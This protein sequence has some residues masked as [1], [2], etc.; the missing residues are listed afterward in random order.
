MSFPF[1][2]NSIFNQAAV[3]AGD[4][5]AAVSG[6]S[7]AAAGEWGVALSSG[8]TGGEATT[9][10]NG[11]SYSRD[12][13]AAAG[14]GGFAIA[15]ARNAQVIAGGSGVALGTWLPFVESG[16]GGLSIS[17]NGGVVSTGDSGVALVV[18]D[19]E[20]ISPR[21]NRAKAGHDGVLILGYLDE[22][23]RSRFAVAYVGEDEILPDTYYY[24]DSSGKVRPANSGVRAAS[25]EDVLVSLA[26][27]NRADFR[28]IG[29]TIVS[30]RQTKGSPPSVRSASASIEVVASQFFDGITVFVLSI[31]EPE[32]DP[33]FVFAANAE[34]GF[35][36]ASQCY[37]DVS[38][39]YKYPT[40]IGEKWEFQDKD[41]GSTVTSDVETLGVR[42]TH[43]IGG[44]TYDR[45]VRY[46]TIS[47]GG[48]HFIVEIFQPGFGLLDR[49]V[50]DEKGTL[51]THWERVPSAKA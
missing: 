20:E 38:L 22:K 6:E 23:G 9:G 16:E 46:R 36:Q 43:E 1:F 50:T 33:S 7:S 29:G 5:E 40:S 10:A 17:R 8:E 21:R 41:E 48:I 26:V 49:V 47:P 35:L 14:E 37:P 19:G 25:G 24:A 2:T 4:N 27:G 45:C 30:E 28:V 13:N 15:L 34:D 44:V 51:L 11:L 31:Q 42:E 3:T 32:A 18:S 12:G 39:R